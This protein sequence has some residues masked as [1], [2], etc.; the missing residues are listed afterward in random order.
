M[1][2]R[3]ERKIVEAQE[4]N[5]EDELARAE[6]IATL[7]MQPPGTVL[8]GP[9]V[10]LIAQEAGCREPVRPDCSLQAN[11]VYRTLSG[12]CNN[13]K[14][15]EFGA[16]RTPFRRLIPSQYEDGFN[17]LRGTMQSR[18]SYSYFFSGGPYKPPNPSPRIVSTTVVEDKKISDV[19]HSYI[20]MQWGQFLDHDIDLAPAFTEECK[21]CELNEQ[22]VPIRIPENDETFGEAGQTNLCM[23]FGRSIPICSQGSKSGLVQPREQLNEITS[24][25][26]GS[27]VYGSSEKVFNAIRDKKTE[28]LRTG[29][30]IPGECSSN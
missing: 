12:I 26:D 16:A 7:M 2:R 15:P 22:C 30:P 18:D 20:L 21:N 19:E 8:S 9:E 25:I 1:L 6:S 24:F 29:P 4:A 13:L 5:N 23:E 28:F 11:E 14:N 27:Q 10:A 17:Q 3:A